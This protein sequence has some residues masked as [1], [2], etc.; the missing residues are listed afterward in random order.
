MYNHFGTYQDPHTPTPSLDQMYN[1]S[2]IDGL[3]L[4]VLIDDSYEASLW[5]Y[6]DNYTGSSENPNYG[7][8][9]DD[10]GAR[11]AFKGAFEGVHFNTSASFVND[12]YTLIHAYWWED[13]SND[14]R[15]YFT[16]S[17]HQIVSSAGD[18]YNSSFESDPNH[19]YAWH[20]HLG[21]KYQDL[22]A[23]VSY[24][25]IQKLKFM[26]TSREIQNGVDDT[27]T[28]AITALTSA[29]EIWSFG[30]AYHFDMIGHASAIEGGYE[31]VSGDG[32]LFLGKH[33]WDLQYTAELS[34]NLEAY[35]RYDDYTL[36]GD[37]GWDITST[38][39]VG[40]GAHDYVYEVNSYSSKDS[41]FKSWMVGIKVH[42]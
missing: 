13:G 10:W 3:E 34:P 31:T 9:F 40:A 8:H 29:P 20:A 30:A 4:G 14:P 38:E 35:V 36:T 22:E 16:A 41:E 37:I 33:H 26:H 24:T 17:P 42:I 2:K 6:R 23:S 32:A 1:L 18:S 39:E 7:S 19:K 27:A 28:G 12:A 11:V 25:D 21:L 5:G 15:S